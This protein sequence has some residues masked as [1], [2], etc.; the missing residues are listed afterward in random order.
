MGLRKTLLV[1][2][3]QEVAMLSSVLNSDAQSAP[4]T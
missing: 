1:F 3:E 4:E 2:T